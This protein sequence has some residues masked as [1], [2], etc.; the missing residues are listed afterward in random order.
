MAHV[1]VLPAA[2][3]LSGYRDTEMKTIKVLT[4]N[5]YV[6]DAERPELSRVSLKP[7]TRAL[8]MEHNIQA[9]MAV[10]IGYLALTTGF[11]RSSRLKSLQNV[12]AFILLPATNTDNK[13]YLGI[14][15][16]VDT[17]LL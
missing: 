17:Y 4:G 15:S 12:D 1:F 6:L 16:V 8:L 7:I 10:G 3:A 5:S 14:G 2:R 9:A 13:G 11:Q